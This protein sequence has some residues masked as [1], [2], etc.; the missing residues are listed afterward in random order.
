MFV[1]T[2]VSRWWAATLSIPKCRL[3]IID[4]GT[5]VVVYD[6]DTAVYRLL[7]LADWQVQMP[8]YL[9]RGKSVV[10]YLIIFRVLE[11]LLALRQS[12]KGQPLQGILLGTR[13]MS[14]SG[15]LTITATVASIVTLFI[16]LYY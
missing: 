4:H 7:R 3:Q 9:E 16:W 11:V 15:A 6:V 1:F 13:T 14:P 12:Q 8:F 5:F 10:K 2:M